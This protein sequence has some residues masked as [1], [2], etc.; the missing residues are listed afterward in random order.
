MQQ[1]EAR[2]VDRRGMASVERGDAGDRVVEQRCVGRQRLA[3]GID[4]VGQ[5]HEAQIAIGAGEM[6]DLQSRHLLGDR[7][8]RRQQHRDDDERAQLGRHAV[9]QLQARQRRGAELV[10]GVA[11]DESG[12]DVDRRHE[13]EQGQH[14]EMPAGD[15]GMPRDEQRESEDHERQRRDDRDVTADADA[16]VEAIDPG[17]EWG[18][19]GE[20]ALEIRA[21]GGDEVVAGIA[22]ARRRALAGGERQVRC[23]PRAGDDDLRDLQLAVRRAARE[24]LDRAAIAVARREIHRGEVAARAQRRVDQT[25]LL[26]Q[27]SPVHRGDQ[28]HAGDDVA[29][30]D[31]H[32]PLA[33]MFGAHGAVAI[34]A[35]A[36]QAILEP[37]QRR[38][39]ARILVAQTLDELRHE[40]GRQRRLA[41]GT[42]LLHRRRIAARREQ[43]VGDRVRRAPRGTARH[44]GLG[45]AAQILD[46]DDAQRD[47]HRPELAD[48]ERLHRL[49][50]L[51]EARQQLR[52]ETAVRMRDEGPGETEDAGVAGERAVGELRQLSV[53]AGRQVGADL[54]DLLLDDVEVVDQPFGRRRDLGALVDRFRDRAVGLE[55]R[56]AVVGEA[57]RQRLA[58][59]RRRRHGLRV[60]E[61][62]GVQQQPFGAEQLGADELAAGQRGRRATAGE[63]ASRSCF[64]WNLSP[65]RAGAGGATARGDAIGRADGAMGIGAIGS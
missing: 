64:Q 45:G 38:R 59:G 5:Q 33:V 14:A 10:H 1:Q 34:R 4:P 37:E 54:A 3:G 58:V 2:A 19:I 65:A 56:A 35:L 48:L 40:G 41:L 30:G 32:R 51:H 25:D 17:R 47:R 9:A 21:S 26:E 13:A 15:A 49:I 22:G 31:V 43:A 55:Q 39:H 23:G 57:P 61:A 18:A 8:G 12:R 52:I 63:Q 29:H 16:R 24:H 27:L 20:R 6:Q 28:P 53:I 36:A 42:Q 50:G 60:R 44:D 46:Q 7:L 11:I 62:V